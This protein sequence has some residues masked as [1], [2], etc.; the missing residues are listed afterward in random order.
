MPWYVASA[1]LKSAYLEDGVQ[2]RLLDD[3]A[4]V[5]QGLEFHGAGV[6]QVLELAEV[7]DLDDA[8]VLG[9]FQDVQ[10]AG[11]EI[12]GGHHLQV[13]LGHQFGGGLIQGP[14]EDRAAP[15][16]GDAVGHVGPVVGLGQGAGPGGAAGV[17]VLQDG[18]GGLGLQVLDDI[19]AV[20]QVGQVGLAGVLARLDHG[21]LVN[22]AGEAV[23]GVQEVAAAQGEVAAHQFVERRLLAG[24][25]AV[26]Q[27]HFDDLALGVGHLP[28]AFAVDQLLV[29]EGDGQ[30]GGKW[31]AITVRYMAL[32]SLIRSASEE[33]FLLAVGCFR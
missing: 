22:G 15:E 8:Q 11:L 24:I 26:A 5:D 31:S 1:G 30:V 33:S 7:G 16:G 3:E 9:L 32:I 19:K 10:G 20:V 12:R 23:I 18:G 6:H 28:G 29:A 25:F 2:G 27:P 14:V 4:A 21:R 17:V 13:I